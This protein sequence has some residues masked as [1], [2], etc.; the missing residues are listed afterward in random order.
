MPKLF[1][2]YPLTIIFLII[3]IGLSV[4]QKLSMPV[5][6]ATKVDY[7]KDTFWHYPWGNL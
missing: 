2:D 5:D 4:P 7:N 3:A 1:K 6:G